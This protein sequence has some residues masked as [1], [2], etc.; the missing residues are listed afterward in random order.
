VKIWIASWIHLLVGSL[1][2]RLVERL[3]QFVCL[4]PFIDIL[5]FAFLVP[6]VSSL[7]CLSL[8]HLASLLQTILGKS[9]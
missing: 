6:I 2:G 5:R 1:P 9:P 7:V 3:V 8:F 4:Y